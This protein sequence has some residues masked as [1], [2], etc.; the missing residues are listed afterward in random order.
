MLEDY[1]RSYPQK[2]V[3]VD[4]YFLMGCD[5][6]AHGCGY[7]D[8]NGKRQMT[9]PLLATRRHYERLYNIIKAADPEYGW[10]RIH[11]WGPMMPIAAFC[12][13]N[14]S[15]EGLIGPIGNTPEKNYYRVVDLPYAR[16]EFRNEQWGHFQ[17][18]L[19]ELGVSAGTDPERRAE[20]FG[21]M[22]SPP[23]DGKRGEWVIPRMAD[24]DHV[25]GLALIH[26]MWNIGGNDAGISAQR[27][28]KM[29]RE[30]GWDEAV[31]FRGYW[32]L[33]DR[34]IVDGGVP[35]QI[36]CSLFYRPAGKD[37]DG[38]PTKPWLMLAAM[39]N[40]DEDATITLRP[41]LKMFGLESL[42]N[43]VMRDMYAATGYV[44]D[45]PTVLNPGDP[46]PPY[47]VI[48][49]EEKLFAM[50]SGAAQVSIPK[51]HFRALLLESSAAP[52]SE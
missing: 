41:N 51:R 49:P 37:A 32:E 40:S 9:A 28:N 11:D 29:M 43:G 2:G 30:M 35:E 18:W 52:R 17:N 12:D 39:N 46:E 21:K 19:T 6:E 31:R 16:I 33:G 50:K 15:G 42:A 14:W 34:L 24:Y 3:Y 1:M 36:V 13:E 38:K 4:C 45:L 7:V 26:D 27:L 44:Y 47:V 20:W 5:N 8:E 10:L 25:A 23:K 22:I 48:D